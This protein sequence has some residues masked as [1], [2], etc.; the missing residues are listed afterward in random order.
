MGEDKRIIDLPEYQPVAIPAGE[1][2]RSQLEII[3]SKFSMVVDVQS[4][5]YGDEFTLINRG[6]AGS[7]PIDRSLSLRLVPKLPISN[8]FRMMEY[9]YNTDLKF[10]KGEMD[11][12][13]IEDIFRIIA[14][15]LALRILMRA[16][17]GLYREYKDRRERLPYLR[18]RMDIRDR[19][20]RPHQISFDCTYQ[21]FTQDIA[22]NRIALYALFLASRY[23]DI[24]PIVRKAMRILS[25]VSLLVHSSMDID[26]IVYNRLSEDYRMIHGL[27]RFIIENT[28]PTIN[29]DG[30]TLLPFHINM[31]DLFERFVVG[32]L[33]ENTDGLVIHAQRRCFIDSNGHFE[34]IF[35]ILIEDI[36]SR[37]NLCII[38]T[39]Y[40][41]PDRPSSHDIDQIIA[42]CAT[43]GDV[44]RG[45]LLYP[46]AV[47]IPLN[48]VREK[49]HVQSMTFDITADIDEG[50]RTFLAEL[51][52]LQGVLP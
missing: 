29:D 32:W 35:D 36:H 47:R 13:D 10:N 19:I 17:K 38:D 28:G 3:R 20:A 34:H 21:D 4:S 2:A 15:L 7:L 11:V 33:R 22:E 40:K 49:Y 25:G 45:I 12:S 5:F 24:D 50:G 14:K 46:R 6:F 52:I 23:P 27:S 43:M 30:R 18:G 31:A 37:E 1:I 39:K 8:I 51:G 26:D 16:K 48:A 41:T 9:A 42:Y 44:Q